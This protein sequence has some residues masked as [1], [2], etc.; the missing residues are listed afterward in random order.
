MS[1]FYRPEADDSDQRA[2][3]LLAALKGAH[4][5][6]RALKS[7]IKQITAFT[8]ER[9]IEMVRLLRG[10]PLGFADLLEQSGMTSS[11]LSRGLRK[12]QRRQIV[13]REKKMYRLVKPDD[14]LGS[15]LLSIVCQKK[16]RSFQR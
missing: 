3:R 5:K 7:V 11:A 12:L 6:G 10:G 9:R 4:D 1:V 2:V 14:E 8:H 15:A 16:T 13:F